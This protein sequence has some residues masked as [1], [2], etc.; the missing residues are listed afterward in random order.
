MQKPGIWHLFLTL[1]LMILLNKI[2]SNNQKES[3]TDGRGGVRPGAGR[4]KGAKDRVTVGGILEALDAR[5]GGQSYEDI[6]VEDFLSARL[7]GDTM[8]THKYHTLLSNK[9][10]ANLNE[11]TVEEVGDGV[12]GK[13]AAFH[14]AIK[15]LTALNST[16]HINNTKDT[17]HAI[18]KK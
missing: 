16:E 5:T 12:D 3:K 7:M 14:E 13:I 15:A 18:S 9:F 8:L 17:N 1:T 2:M 11:I 4:K 10:V 6:L